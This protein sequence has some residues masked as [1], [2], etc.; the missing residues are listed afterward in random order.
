MYFGKLV[1]CKVLYVFYGA[2]WSNKNIFRY[3][4]IF[5]F[6]PRQILSERIVFWICFCLPCFPFGAVQSIP[7]SR[8]INCANLQSIPS[9]VRCY[10]FQVPVWLP[11]ISRFPDFMLKTNFFSVPQDFESRVPTCCFRHLQSLQR[12]H[13]PNK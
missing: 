11:A 12:S 9:F 4:S 13:P 3:M 1:H 8:S 6:N 5:L 7:A 10:Q 2:A